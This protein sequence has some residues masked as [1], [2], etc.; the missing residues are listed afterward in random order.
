MPALV[1]STE[2]VERSTYI[3]EVTFSDENGLPIAPASL[4]WTLT[5]AFGAVINNRQAVAVTPQAQ[6]SIV[7]KDG[8]LALPGG[9]DSGKRYLLLE[10][11]YDSTLGAGL[12]LREE[13]EFSVRNLV[14]VQ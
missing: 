9:M 10:G 12:P 5:D 2:A 4:T 7:L 11:A 8:D 14:K 1:V 13:V 3:V 6:V